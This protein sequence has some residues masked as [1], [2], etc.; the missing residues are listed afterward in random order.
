MANKSRRVS[1]P[2]MDIETK[3]LQIKFE[4]IYLRERLKKN[5]REFDKW[6]KKLLKTTGGYIQNA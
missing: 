4:E 1:D 2:H 3:L 5:E 6:S